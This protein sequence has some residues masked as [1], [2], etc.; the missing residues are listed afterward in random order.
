MCI[1]S[2]VRELEGKKPQL[3]ELI[4]LSE[5]LKADGGRQKMCARSKLCISFII[6][7]IRNFT[8]HLNILFYSINVHSNRKATWEIFGTSNKNQI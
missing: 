2:V 1:Q 5:A 3:D 7:K 8:I 4:L 6:Y